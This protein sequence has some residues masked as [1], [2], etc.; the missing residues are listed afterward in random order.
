MLV[1]QNQAEI[2]AYPAVGPEV[3]IAGC[4][5]LSIPMTDAHVDGNLVTAPAWPAHPVW[6]AKYLQC[7]SAA[8]LKKLRAYDRPQERGFI[9]RQMSA[10][11]FD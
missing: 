11:G 3:T 2:S 8:L 7:L 10:P 1:P 4:E 9:G 5:Y 6:L